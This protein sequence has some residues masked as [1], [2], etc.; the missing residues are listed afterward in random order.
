MN[1]FL[2][3]SKTH[4]QGNEDVFE[5]NLSHQL[6]NANGKNFLNTSY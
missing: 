2:Q 3:K 1:I 6:Q 5:E 4:Y